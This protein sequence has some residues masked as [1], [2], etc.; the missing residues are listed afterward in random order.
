MDLLPENHL[1][2]ACL[3]LI[4]YRNRRIRF[5]AELTIHYWSGNLRATRLPLSTYLDQR[6]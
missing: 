3:I 6:R 4:S 2:A 1:L 5:T